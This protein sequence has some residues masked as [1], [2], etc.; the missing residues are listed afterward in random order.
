MVMDGNK[1]KVADQGIRDKVALRLKKSLYGLKQAG[2]LWA[3]FLHKTLEELC[4]TQCYTDS[5]L[6][7][8]RDDLETTIVGV[9]VDDLLVT[10]TKAALVD[11]FF[12]DMHMLEMKDLGVVK[13]F[14]GM[15]VTYDNEHGYILEQ[16]SEGEDDL[17][18]GGSGG[19]TQ[20]P[21][22]PTSARATQVRLEMG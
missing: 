21:N 13:K 20:R 1:L 12:Q 18:P 6:Y 22:I 16:D 10:S 8:K 9:Y 14:L 4:F 17:L 5:C 11:K 15:G 3:E 2:R 19:T 7:Y